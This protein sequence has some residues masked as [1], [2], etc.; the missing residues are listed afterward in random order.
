DGIEGALKKIGGLVYGSRLQTPNAEEASHMY[1]GNGLSAPFLELLATHPP[2]EE[3]IRRID[4]RFDGNFP[5]VQQIEYTP[6]DLIDPGTLAS[7]RAAQVS[8]HAGAMAGAQGFAFAP[9][10]AVAQVGAPSPDHLEYAA[11]LVDSLPPEL[12]QDVRDPL[13][14]VATIYALLL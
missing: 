14:A 2:L 10:A 6:K 8:V 1:F 4:P 11:A 13:G 12:A 5:A 7:R 9:E 3:R